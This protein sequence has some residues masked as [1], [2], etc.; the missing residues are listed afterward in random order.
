MKL[1]DVCHGR[2]LLAGAGNSKKKKK[3]HPK[4]NLTHCHLTDSK[5]TISFTE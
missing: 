2:M 5:A 1:H 4:P 3:Q